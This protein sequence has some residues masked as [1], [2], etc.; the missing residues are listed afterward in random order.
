MMLW[1]DQW[2]QKTWDSIDQD[3]DLIIIGGGI[4]GAGILREAVN[5]GYQV[6]LLDAND[7]AFGTSSRSSKLIHGGFRYLAN[8]QF[9]VTRESVIEREWM[10]QNARHLV[11]PLKFL[12]PIYER[13]KAWQYKLGVLIYDWMA[14]HWDHKML[15][16]RQV[17]R[18]CPILS[19]EGLREGILYRDAQM[20][21]SRF[22]IRLL[23]ECVRD[24]G[25]ALNYAR[26]TGL[27]R[28]DAGVVNGVSVVDSSGFLE[29]PQF[30]RTVYLHAK[31][32][33]NAAG[34]W[35]DEIRA[36]MPAGD[37][38][39]QL[40]GS[41]LVFPAEKFPLRHA[42][43]LRHPDDG[44][45][46][47]ALPW[48][49]TVLIG[50]TD[51]DHHLPPGEPGGETFC[52][53]DEVDYLMRAV[54]VIFPG[55]A[56][57]HADIISS[58][59]GL[60]PIISS[61]KENPSDES[62]AHHVWVE[63]GM[64]SVGGGKFT[65]FRVMA[66]DVMRSAETILGE[67]RS[68]AIRHGYFHPLPERLAASD[69]ECL[70]PETM[71]YLSGRYGAD[72]SALVESGLPD[73]CS[74]ILHLPNVWAELRWAVRAEG[75]VHLDDLL[76][77]RVRLGLLLPNAAENVMPRIRVIVQDA[78]G[79]DDEKWHDEYIRYRRIWQ[80]A[81]SPVPGTEPEGGIE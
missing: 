59:A 61:G 18:L 68:E 4:T 49:G 29:P 3:W 65:I 28:D 31:I 81:Y 46:M 30:S 13:K 1:N 32:V 24:G 64:V 42:V 34:P 72:L 56:V 25:T 20:D 79:W 10:L 7:F 41:H 9:D 40:R 16:R 55:A 22:V 43:T 78:L 12:I 70:S 52:T 44:R 47:F 15:S 11:T 67:D 73:E 54:E 17:E 75:V 2:R 62:R 19:R 69:L 48:E 21:D 71:N 38:I 8:R 63:D 76:L 74:R 14:S 45:A 23:R 66:Q 5:R 58:M 77:R 39:R 50:T 27:L 37:K 57:S 51:L 33:I 26:V 80:Q 60:R 35:S 36:G 53:R 6:L